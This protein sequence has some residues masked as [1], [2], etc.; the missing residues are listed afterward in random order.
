MNI[1][2]ND[3]QQVA[4]R[5][6]QQTT[7]LVL[8]PG[9][10]IRTPRILL[11]S[12]QGDDRMRGHNLLRRAILNH[13]VPR[14]NG[15]VVTPPMAA[16]T[17]FTFSEGNKV[18]EANQLESIPPMANIG[19]EAYWLDAGWFEGGWPSG[20][21]SWFPR[22]DAF[23]NGLKP[24]ADVAHKLG[25]KFIVWFEPERVH[26]ASRIA[27]EHPDWVLHAGGGDGLFN[28]ADPAARKWLTDHLAKVIE[29]SGIDIYRNDFNIDPLRFWK[30]ADAPNRQGMTEIRY[31]EGLYAMWD[32]LIQ[33]KP[34]L[35]IDNCSSG[36]R[37]IDLEM[38]SRSVPLWRSD[39][40]CC[41]HALHA[42]DQAQI[43]GLSLYVPLHASGLWG[44][45][46]YTFRSLV[47]TG[48][49]LS[50]DTRKADFPVDQAKAAIAE[51]K[52]LRPYW[53]GDFCPL[54]PVN[55][56]EQHWCGW[57]LHRPDLD[58]GFAVFF[59]RQNSPYLAMDSQLKGLDASAIYAVSFCEGYVVKETRQMSGAELAKLSVSI[60]AASGC[61][62]IKY[63]RGGGNR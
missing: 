43:A 27:K 36:G 2:R 35:W 18:T 60:P 38:L 26:P 48:A 52:S 10:S 40:A 50:L 33:R 30:A 57:Q 39:T 47:T 20:V 55:V 14:I 56:D 21:G 37:R 46:P 61:L 15:Q 58:A 51:L 42:Q 59:R 11:V 25:M 49:S 5:A 63:G 29:E 7:R 8:H 6:G 22:K 31:V 44:V 41:G 54:S 13:Y 53:Q 23:P 12:W 45:D 19:I 28:L 3:N 32:D 9:E 4:I 34:G 24:M 1:T 62:M 16:N 17:W